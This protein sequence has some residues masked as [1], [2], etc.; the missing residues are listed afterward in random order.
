[1]D[2]LAKN[3]YDTNPYAYALNNQITYIDLFGLDPLNNNNNF[4]DGEWGKF[5]TDKGHIKL[6]EVSVN[7]YQN[8][9]S[10]SKGWNDTI[11]N[12]LKIKFTSG[13]Y[14]ELVPKNTGMTLETYQNLLKQVEVYNGTKI[15]VINTHSEIIAAFPI[16]YD[17][18]IYTSST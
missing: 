8:N 17:S 18:K 15:R 7:G 2:P 3:H 12:Q 4:K 10:W 1:M 6:D 13:I 5:N 16:K 11:S 9:W 14:F